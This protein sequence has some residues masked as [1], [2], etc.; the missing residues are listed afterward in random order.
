MKKTIIISIVAIV[1]VSAFICFVIA[2]LMANMKKNSD[3]LLGAKA[4]FSALQEQ[5][6]NLEQFK[7]TRQVLE[8]DRAKADALFI[9]PDMP[10]SFV[11]LLEDIADVS[12]IAISIS[13]VGSK[14]TKGDTWPSMAFRVSA[15]GSAAGCFKFLE[16][17]ET[18]PSLLE[19]QNFSISAI[20][21]EETLNR[22]QLGLPLGE[23]KG[24]FLLKV[25]SI[26][27]PR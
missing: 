13:P 8:Y 15:A 18:A 24:D 26:K 4:T 16:R 11:Q 9:D 19:I 27:Q 20:K 1:I 21:E 10:L 17:L 12:Q 6:D 14:V 2:P 25:Y 22:Q 7:A 3:D 5:I 23:V